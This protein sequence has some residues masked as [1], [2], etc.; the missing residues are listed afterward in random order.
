MNKLFACSPTAA[1]LATA[2][3][4]AESQLVPFSPG[5][6]KLVGNSVPLATRGLRASTKYRKSVSSAGS[7]VKK[8][9]ILVSRRARSFAANVDFDG[10][11]GKMTCPCLIW[12]TTF[13]YL[14]PHFAR[15][16]Q[17]CESRDE[18]APNI[19]TALAART[20]I[21]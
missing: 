18:D 3:V 15:S 8:S 16:P 20:Q 21:C 19:A 13:T 14:R 9:Q 5:P 1:I 4:S 6:P 17:G 12:F 10:K 2:T 7:E 11:V